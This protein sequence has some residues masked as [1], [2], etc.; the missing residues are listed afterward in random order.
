MRKLKEALMNFRQVKKGW[1]NPHL[2][3][4]NIY[5]ESQGNS[6]I[7]ESTWKRAEIFHTSASTP[8]MAVKLVQIFLIVS[9]HRLPQPY[10]NF[11][12]FFLSFRFVPPFIW[13]SFI[14]FYFILFCFTI[15]L[16]NIEKVTV[17]KSNKRQVYTCTYQLTN[18]TSA[19]D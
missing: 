10:F 16:N 18:T 3:H 6:H 4:D 14:L 15:S 13:F 5:N 17:T 8:I 1:D 7:T 9:S 12:L 19:W 2:C 11:V